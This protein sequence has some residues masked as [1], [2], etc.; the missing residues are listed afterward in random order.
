MRRKLF[1]GLLIAAPSAAW[2]GPIADQFGSGYEGVTWGLRLADLVGMMP[3]GDHY[4]S[5]APGKRVYVVKNDAP[6]FGVPRE[7]TR[8]QYHLGKDG[9]VEHIAIGVPY[10]R[11][12][13]VLSSLN[14]QFGGY[15]AHDFGPA[16]CY[17]WGE[18]RQ[19]RLSLCVSRDPR[20]GIAEVWINHVSGATPKRNGK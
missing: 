9:G 20:Y 13:Q 11:R 3:G 14:L 1:A 19:V 5:T 8:V 6:L 10:E 7:G 2:C 17:M 15:V 12:E 16:T 4:W 18:D